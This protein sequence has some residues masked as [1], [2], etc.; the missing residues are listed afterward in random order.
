MAQLIVG[1]G[2]FKQESQT[3]KLTPLL[4]GTFKGRNDGI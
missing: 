3:G 2:T 4:L 1:K